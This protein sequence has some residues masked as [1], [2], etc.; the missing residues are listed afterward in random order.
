M[1]E[2]HNETTGIAQRLIIHKNQ[3]CKNISLITEDKPVPLDS[4]L[5]SFQKDP[6]SQYTVWHKI[7]KYLNSTFTHTKY[8]V[9]FFEIKIKIK[10]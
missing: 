8:I 3:K 5:K 10:S 4:E 6:F 7:L 2:P 9:F 1:M